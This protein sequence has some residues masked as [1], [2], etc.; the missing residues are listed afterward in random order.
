MRRHLGLIVIFLFSIAGAG[1]V[2]GTNYTNAR[3]KGLPT[4]VITE[5]GIFTS[6]DP[7]D[8]DSSQNLPVARMIYATPLEMMPDNS[9]GSQVLESFDYDAATKTVRW[10]VREGNTFSNGTP[11]TAEDIA[12]SVTRMAFAR[13]KFPLIKLIEGI[14]TWV[15]EAAPLTTYPSGIKVEGNVI[16]IRLTKDYPHPLFRF[17]LELFSIIPKSCVDLSSNKITCEQIPMS[18]YYTLVEKGDRKV[19]FAR[20][21]GVSQIQGRSY[22]NEIQ[23]LYRDAMDAFWGLPLES[24]NTVILSS[25]SKVPKEELAKVASHFHIG[26]T[27][28]AWFTILQLNPRVHPFSDANCRRLFAEAFRKNHAALSGGPV[29]SSVFTK[30]VAGYKDQAELQNAL[31]PDS[32]VLGTCRKKMMG[33][34]VPWGFESSTPDTFSKAIVQTA[35]GL[36]IE[37]LGP[38]KFSSR[39]DEV[40]NFIAGKSAM[41]YGRTGFWALDPSG[42]I[43]MLFTPNLHKGLQHFWQDEK[44][45]DLLAVVVKD[46][47]VDKNVFDA[48]NAY[49]FADAKFNVYSHI[50][51]FYASKNE[52][53]VR[54]FP[55][56]ITSPSPWQLFEGL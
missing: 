46:G 51:R 1:L 30:M 47:K 36:G 13:P 3:G 10:V 7:L 48:I 21:S 50:R 49:L 35:E 25:E 12:F 55:I 4:L 24:E 8:A 29:E 20:R 22:P 15:Q 28:A 34:K 37:I 2:I 11:I 14:E 23:F 17:C 52:N 19:T 45:Q 27:P 32:E 44:L 31:Q 42:D 41:M 38:K 26:Y 16:T 18:G 5:T 39:K 54:H 56:G 9:L 43:Q 6:L 53:L 40:E 33:A